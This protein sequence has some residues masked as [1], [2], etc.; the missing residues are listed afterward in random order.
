M[1]AGTTVFQGDTV[2]TQMG[3]TVLAFGRGD[4]LLLTPNSSVRVADGTSVELLRGM[5]RLQGGSGAV[6]L[7]ASNWVV[8]AKPDA[9]TGRVTADILRDNDGTVSLN[10]RDGELTA[11]N[12][13]TL[14]VAVASAG[15]PVLLPA[16]VLPSDQQGGTN[17]GS[18]GQGNPPQP[19]VAGGGRR[20]PGAV[21]IALVTGAIAGGA[22]A[23]A[24]ATRGESDKISMQAVQAQGAALARLATGAIAAYTKPAQSNATLAAILQQIQGVLN[25]INTINSQLAAGQISTEQASQQLTALNSQLISLINQANQAGQ[26]DPTFSPFRP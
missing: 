22:V 4:S 17:S 5:S 11:R 2:E 1:P 21:K 12:A 15:R 18:A 8:S 13:A 14:Q 9:K 23:A 7:I 24:L 10:V 19:P 26:S 3:N 20:K 6:R 25:Q 16:A